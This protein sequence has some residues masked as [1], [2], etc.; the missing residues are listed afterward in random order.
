[1]KKGKEKIAYLA[2]VIFPCRKPEKSTVGQ[3]EW[4]YKILMSSSTQQE[5]VSADVLNNMPAERKQ[6]IVKDVL[7]WTSPNV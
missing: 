3:V 5:F 2:N 4:R 6:E 7:E 1:M